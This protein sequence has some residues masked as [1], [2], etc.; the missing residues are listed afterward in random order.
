MTYCL[1]SPNEMGPYYY[2]AIICRQLVEGKDEH[3]T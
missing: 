1:L 3:H 2:R